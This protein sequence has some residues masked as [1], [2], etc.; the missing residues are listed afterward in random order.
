[1]SNTHTY[2]IHVETLRE[3]WPMT[4]TRDITSWKVTATSEQEAK[5]E[6]LNLAW[7]ANTGGQAAFRATILKVREIT[8]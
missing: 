6:A 2:I 4:C 3:E 7:C 5:D 1:M 8:L